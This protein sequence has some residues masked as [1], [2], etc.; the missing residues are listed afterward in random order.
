MSCS[1]VLGPFEAAPSYL[2]R[3]FLATVPARPGSAL[4]FYQLLATDI[5]VFSY[6]CHWYLLPFA[7]ISHMEKKKS[8][9]SFSL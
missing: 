2:S 6:F 5:G 1:S 9:F 7:F 8:I 3:I 4:R